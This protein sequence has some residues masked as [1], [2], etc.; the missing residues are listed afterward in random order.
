MRN[1]M[2]MTDQQRKLVVDNMNYA[3]M[4]AENYK[5]RGV[6]LC[7]LQQEA[8]LALC[9]AAMRF[10]PDKGFKLTTFATLY[11]H[12]CLSKYVMRYG[13][14]SYLTKEQRFFVQIVSLDNVHDNDDDDD[15]SNWEDFMHSPA[16]DDDS[17]KQEAAEMVQA[18]MECLD[19]QEKQILTMQYDLDDSHMTVDQQAEA[20]GISVSTLNRRRN[21]IKNKLRAA[22][23]RYNINR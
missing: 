1:E 4:L 13:Y 12:G 5:G 18:L 17:E 8:R 3:D 14:Q 23:E 11:I 16:A 6:M 19:D 10:D 15:E 21:E 20:M 7:D 2:Q 9:Y 22:A